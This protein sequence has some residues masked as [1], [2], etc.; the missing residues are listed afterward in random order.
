[1]A[2]EDISVS[3][4]EASESLEVTD[5]FS[6]TDSWPNTSKLVVFLIGHVT[7]K[8]EYGTKISLLRNVPWCKKMAYILFL[9]AWKRQVVVF[10]LKTVHVFL[11]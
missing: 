10:F 7:K 5:I 8:K 4:A 9:D 11:G 2:C 3:E 1:M 6:S